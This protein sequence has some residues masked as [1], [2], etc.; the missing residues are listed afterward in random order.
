MTLCF[1]W[2]SFFLRGVGKGTLRASTRTLA[3]TL[4]VPVA[5]M[6]K[7]ISGLGWTRVVTCLCQINNPNSRP[8]WE[9][10]T[11]KKA[12]GESWSEDL[13]EAPKDRIR[14]VGSV[15]QFIEV[16]KLRQMT[17]TNLGT[18]GIFGTLGTLGTLGLF[19]EAVFFWQFKSIQVSRGRKNDVH[20]SHVVKPRAVRCNCLQSIDVCWILL[21]R[22]TTYNDNVPNTS[23]YIATL[24]NHWQ[25][26]CTPTVQ[27]LPSGCHTIRPSPSKKK[28]LS[29]SRPQIA[30][31]RYQCDTDAM[32]WTFW[33]L[34]LG[35]YP[36]TWLLVCQGFQPDQGCIN[37]SPSGRISHHK[38]RFEKLEKCGKCGEQCGEQCGEHVYW[39]EIA[40]LIDSYLHLLILLHLTST[41]FTEQ[42]CNRLCS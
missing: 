40:F 16:C 38:L 9:T 29:G 17:R 30:S 37:Q 25:N 26:P 3:S 20:Q 14:H 15:E 24:A 28:T 27:I 35:S 11:G 31:A 5:H 36:S 8:R 33:A 4:M 41:Y 1:L 6:S 42:S 39:N 12:H 34:F 2:V 23:K 32:V 19:T 18:L 22:L 21:V 13:S 10:I 7:T